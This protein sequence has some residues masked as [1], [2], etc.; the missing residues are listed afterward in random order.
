MDEL[1]NAAALGH[2]LRTTMLRDFERPTPSD[3]QELWGPLT[4]T[5]IGRHECLIPA[6]MGFALKLTGLERFGPR[7]K[8]TS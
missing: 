6:V 3:H 7:E 5:D 1:P 2:R 8:V 4:R